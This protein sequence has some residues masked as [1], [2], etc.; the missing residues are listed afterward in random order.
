MNEAKIA[1]ESRKHAKKAKN[2]TKASHITKTYIELRNYGKRRRQ[3]DPPCG[4]E[5]KKPRT[6][7]DSATQRQQGDPG[8]M[9]RINIT[10][11]AE[12]QQE[13]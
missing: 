3:H 10:G 12:Y 6:S 5:M 1:K 13:K 8:T 9:K 4:G 11:A 7:V 2:R